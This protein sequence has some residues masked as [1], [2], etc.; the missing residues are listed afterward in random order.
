MLRRPPAHRSVNHQRRA[1]HSVRSAQHAGT[2]SAGQQPSSTVVPQF[3][4]RAAK[5]RTEQGVNREQNDDHSKRGLHRALMSARQQPQSQRNPSQRG[6]HQPRRAAQMN[7]LPV[8]HHYDS[9]DGNRD[10]HREWGSDL[11]RDVEGEQRNRDQ[12]LAKAE[13]RSNQ[14][15][16][17][18]DA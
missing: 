10:Q 15:G 7:F 3:E 6:E 4:R 9:G 2:E 17:K 13:R 5:H 14:R 16:H 1:I 12:G 18:Q 8:L 11:K